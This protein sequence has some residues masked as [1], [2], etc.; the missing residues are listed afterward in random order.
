MPNAKSNNLVIKFPLRGE[1]VTV[2]TPGHHRFAFDLVAVQPNSQRYFSSSWFHL[3]VSLAPVSV[4][5]SWLQ[6]VYS[7]VS[8]TVLK[9]S[10]GWSDRLTL[11]V[12]RDILKA[13]VFPPALID[14]DIR[15]F[16]GNYVL[17]E[18]EGVVVMLAHLR[19]GSLKIASGETVQTNQLIGEIGNSGNLIVPHL[20]IQVM[21]AVDPLIATILPFGV[22][23]CEVWDSN[24]WQPMNGEFLK[25][26]KHIRSTKP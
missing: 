4:S 25:K 24:I 12:A 7:P 19:C 5:Y 1:W 22:T 21:D 17:I 15:P 9:A 14:D 13:F 11:N 8:G 20:H 23:G 10:D 2:N 6:P 18:S 26:R 16:A 3:A